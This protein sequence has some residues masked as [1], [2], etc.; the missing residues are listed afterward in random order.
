[1]G[2][3]VLRWYIQVQKQKVESLIETALRDRNTKETL[4]NII[5]KLID[6]NITNDTIKEVNGGITKNNWDKKN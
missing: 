4:L 3:N 5:N 1:M 2:E 6:L